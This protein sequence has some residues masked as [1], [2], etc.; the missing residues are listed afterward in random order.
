MGIFLFGEL[1]VHSL[2]PLTLDDLEALES[3]APDTALLELF[4]EYSQEIPNREISFSAFLHYRKTKPNWL[5]P[6]QC[7][8]KIKTA[9]VLKRVQ[10][11]CFGTQ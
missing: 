3:L 4:G 11:D 8:V 6:N 9:E 2:I 1:T 5:P 7:L 10:A